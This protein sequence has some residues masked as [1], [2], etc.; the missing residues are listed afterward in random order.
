MS[1]FSEFLYELRK[2]KNLTQTELAGKLGI[3]NKA[4]SKWETG[5]AMPDT[6]QLL[7]LAEILDV[8]V[9]EL[10]R[11]E[12]SGKPDGGEREQDDTVEISPQG[13]FIKNE[14]ESV[15]ISSRGV[16]V[17][18]RKAEHR[19]ESVLGRI[20]G[21]VCGSL[22]AVAVVV[23]VILGLT[24]G[25]WHP[26]WCIPAS[27]AIG[28]GIV[29]GIFE[30]FD[31]VARER[32]KSKGENPYTGCVCG[33]IMCASLIIFLCVASVLNLWNIMWISPVVGVCICIIIGSIGA[34]CKPKK[35]GSPKEEE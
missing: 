4:V 24:V 2:E 10:L 11:G 33:I 31:P 25:G 22:V 18:G 20:S 21:C 14:K 23:Y 30:M 35:E 32:K 6:A 27:A 17:N 16:F 3:T 12:R 13:V 19:C 29:G 9:D 15:E 8:T 26:L 1:K 5:E 34:A 28:C 7:P